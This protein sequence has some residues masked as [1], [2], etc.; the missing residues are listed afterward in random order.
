MS[1]DSGA[2]T[3]IGIVIILL[4]AIWLVPFLSIWAINGLFGTGI[5]QSLANWGYVWVIKLV[6]L[7]STSFKR[8]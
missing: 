3:V 5:E 6:A 7:N 4:L 2:I 8:S 1:E